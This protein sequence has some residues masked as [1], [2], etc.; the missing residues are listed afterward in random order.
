MQ[1][2]R[3]EMTLVYVWLY[4]LTRTLD[5]FTFKHSNIQIFTPNTCLTAGL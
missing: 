1:L 5:I 4:I 3:D 2:A